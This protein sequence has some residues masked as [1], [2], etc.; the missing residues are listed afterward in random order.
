MLAD[1]DDAGLEVDAAALNVASADASP[2]PADF[3]RD[4]DRGGTD[5]PLDGDI[6]VGP[7]DTPISRIRR[8]TFDTTERLTL[9]DNA[10]FDL[11]AYFNTGGDGND[12][13]VW[14]QTVDDVAEM[15]VVETLNTFGGNFVQFGLSTANAA[16]IDAIQSGDRYIFAVTRP[17]AG[18]QID[19]AAT[20]ATG[21]VTG[22]A[23]LT[24]TA[25][26][27]TRPDQP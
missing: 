16:I 21:A 8:N 3:Y 2:T 19:L 9:N 12:L 6:G 13:T 27:A 7:G 24:V 1:F 23:T 18:P 20:G 15:V 5:S 4:S 22:T 11:G 14:I 26:A 17:V 25:G 10:T